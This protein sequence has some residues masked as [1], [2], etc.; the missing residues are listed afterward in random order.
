MEAKKQVEVLL[1]RHTTKLREKN[2]NVFLLPS[3]RRVIAPKSPS[4]GRA[5]KNKLAFLKKMLRDEGLDTR[6][7]DE[8]GKVLA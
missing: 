1:R 8:R 2:H 4:D 6:V 5:W 3:G 7:C